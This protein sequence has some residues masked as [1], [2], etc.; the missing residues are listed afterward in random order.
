MNVNAQSFVPTTQPTSTV[1]ASNWSQTKI[2]E[3]KKLITFGN[4]TVEERVVISFLIQVI[5]QIPE[6]ESDTNKDSFLIKEATKIKE[7]LKLGKASADVG[8]MIRNF[9]KEDWTFYNQYKGKIVVLNTLMSNQFYR[10]T[11]V[12]YNN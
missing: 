8:L 12:S 10:Y 5:S 1:S 3:I 9:T 7:F 4:P 2:E 6:S 11:K